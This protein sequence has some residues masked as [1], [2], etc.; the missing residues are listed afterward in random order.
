M[1]LKQAKFFF[2]LQLLHMSTQFHQ[3]RFSQK[4]NRTTENIATIDEDIT[5]ENCLCGVP[6]NAQY[7]INNDDLIAE[8]VLGGEVTKK[9]KFPW[10]IR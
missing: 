10:T 7:K 3:S 5:D 9:E 4:V 2:L 8:R 1:M 6:Q